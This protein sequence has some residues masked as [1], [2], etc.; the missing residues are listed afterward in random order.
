MEKKSICYD[1]VFFSS[2]TFKSARGNFSFFKNLK[3]KAFDEVYKG[4]S[5]QNFHYEKARLIEQEKLPFSSI[6]D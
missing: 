2:F 3:E 6:E 4:I 1:I 5:L